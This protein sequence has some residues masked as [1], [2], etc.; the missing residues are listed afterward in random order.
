M[1]SLNDSSMDPTLEKTFK[2]HR[3]A[4]NAVSFNPNM[5]QVASGGEG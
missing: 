4:V 5:K 3:G 2:G 1:E